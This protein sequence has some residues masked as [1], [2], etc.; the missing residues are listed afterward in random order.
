MIVFGWQSAILSPI[1]VP[2]TEKV[3]FKTFKCAKEYEEYLI[4]DWEQTKEGQLL[5]AQEYDEL[6]LD[7]AFSIDGRFEVPK[8]IFDRL[9]F[10]SKFSCI[11]M[12]SFFNKCVVAHTTF[13]ET[14]ET[15]N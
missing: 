3:S 14:L 9:Q 4:E 1:V 15:E 2:T 11:G 8:D 5:L 7:G 10:S 6:F 13:S 12:F